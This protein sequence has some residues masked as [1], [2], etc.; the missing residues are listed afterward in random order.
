MK[1]FSQIWMVLLC[2]RLH[3]G[4]VDQPTDQEMFANAN[5][6]TTDPAQSANGSDVAAS[7]SDG[8]AGRT[9]QTEL[10]TP[11]A[12]VEP[13]S[14]PALRVDVDEHKPASARVGAD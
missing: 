14:Q 11:P 7:G 6:S 1:E 9:D 3:G 12:D 5:F 13:R 10:I 8:A 2:T 4:L